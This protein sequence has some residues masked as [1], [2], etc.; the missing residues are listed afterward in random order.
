MRNFVNIIALL[1]ISVSLLSCSGSQ[2]NDQAANSSKGVVAKLV[3]GEVQVSV[4]SDDQQNPQVLYLSDKGIYFVVWEDW[5]NRN[6]P[7]TDFPADTAKFAGADIWGQFINPDGTSCG[8][9]FAITNKLAGNQTAPS[10]AYRPGDK[11]LVAW[12]DTSGS[13]TG[14]YVRYASITS[15]PLTTSC[16]TTVPVVSAPVQVGFTHFEQYDPNATTPGS[17]TFT[18]VGDGTGGTDVTGGA[19]LIP[20]I[21]PRS[22]SITGTYPAEDTNPLTSGPSTPV[23]IQDDGLGKLIGSGASGT[24]NYMTGKL[25]VT[26]IN[27]VDTG[28]TATFTINYSTLSGTTSQMPETLL[29]RKSPKANYDAGKDQFS[30]SWVESRNVN[31]YASVLCFGV[32]PF[33]WAT[34][35]STFLGYLYLSPSLT[36]KTNPLTISA[37]DVMRSERTSSMKLVSTSRAATEET[38]V[39]DFFTNIN[40]PNI[41]SDDTSP[42]TLFVW[43]GERNKATLTCTLDV[44]TGTITST[45]AT[46][47]K[48]DGKVHI[49]GLFDKELILNTVTKWI[50][51]ENTGTGT[52]PSLAVDNI[53]IPRKFLVAWE[54]MRGGSNTKV[55]GQLINSGGGLYNNNRMLSFQDSAGTGSNDAVITNSRQTRPFVSYDAVN[56]RYFV[57]WQDE[58]NSSTSAANIDLYGQHVNLDGSLSGA[59]YAISSNPSNQLAPSIAYNSDQNFKQFLAVWKDARG[60]NTTPSTASDV[61][62]QRFT[63]GQPQ[64]TLLTATTPPAQL[65]PAVIDFGSVNTGTTV[66]RQFLV[67]NTGD[68]SLNIDAIT[69]LPTSPFSIAPTNASILAPDSSTT[70]TVTYAPTSSGSNNSS[71]TITSDGGSQVVALSATG[72]GLNT[73]NITSPSTSALPDANTSGFYSVQMVAAGGFTPFKWSA[74]GLPA[75]LSIN[76]ST[77]LISGTNPMAGDYTVV[78]TVADGTSPTPVTATRTYT[79][80]VGS[81]SINTTPLSAWTE[82]VSYVLSP[83]HSLSATGGTGSFTWLL[84]A[85]SGSL[86]PGITLGNNGVFSGTATGSGQYAFS[87]T[88][89]D[90]SSQTAQAQ[91]SITINPAPVILTTSLQTGIIGLP[92]TQTL[93][94]TGGTLPIVW[95]ITS[96]GLPPGLTFNTATGEI[97][98]TPT[99]SGTYDIT[100][101]ITDSTGASYG[102]AL[103]IIINPALD[104][105]TATTGSAAPTGA[106][107]N[108]SYSFALRTNNGGIAPYTWAVKNGVLPTGLVLDTNSGVISG[109]PTALGNYTFVIELSDLNGTKVSKTF[110]ISVTAKTTTLNVTVTGGTGTVASFSSVATTSLT[111]SPANFTPASAAS[112]TINGV[113]SG[114]TVTLSVTFPSLPA[115]PVFYKVSGTQ[116]TLL[117]PDTIS[118]TTI[119]YQVKDRISATDTDPLALRDSNITPGI[120]DDPIVVGTAGS[121][122][123]TDG[124]SIAPSSGGGGGGGCFIATAAY[125]SYLDPHVMVLRHFRDDVLLQNELGTAFV[126]FYYKHSPPIADFIAHHDTLRMLLR[127]A[128]TPVIFAVKYPLVA[129]VF[130]LLGLCLFITRRVNAKNMRELITTD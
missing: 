87:V 18:I 41:A 38:Y 16:T 117:T 57:I 40:N 89:T 66:T 74:T 81:I 98:G 106:T 120:I 108:A 67:K 69:V 125:G 24:I 26:L 104:I 32:A 52:N 59:N 46:A 73:L 56:Q 84:L 72:S 42:E 128:L 17:T 15:I 127:F 102:K 13:A 100:A 96:G 36:P 4:A 58:R 115:N 47:P 11:I 75:A 43:E 109:T 39:Y 111:G 1:L 103:R 90:G 122:T 45:F 6:Q 61:Y 101:N 83:S 30:L 126:K 7:T 71:F 112:M 25:D 97:S 3:G 14:G 10:V 37:P 31:S 63:I 28:A 22:I 27:E 19:V 99:N 34:G 55:F 88:A 51:Y 124:T 116:W 76:S 91:F 110:T 54:D 78:I 9:A 12:Q 130:F 79:L 62:G 64:L 48:D 44:S 60:I 50:D 113:P 5:R 86:P 121:T 68:A 33:T 107:L 29:S 23:N 114:G 85:N 2:Y 35:D 82:G 70:Y 123:T 119:T 53:N 129:G 65:V 77:G 92:Y 20:Y 93:S 94:K 80:R 21:Q 95:S 49:Y 118:G 105:A 8:S